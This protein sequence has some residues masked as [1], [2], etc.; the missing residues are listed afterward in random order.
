MFAT[1]TA[2]AANDPP[3]NPANDRWGRVRFLLGT[4]KGI[5]RS[6]FKRKK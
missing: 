6:H 2:S 5:G 3:V 1:L 4:W